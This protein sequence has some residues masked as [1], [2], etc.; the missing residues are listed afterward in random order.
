MAEE[1][2]E[3]FSDRHFRFKEGGETSYEYQVPQDRIE[4]LNGMTVRRI[5]VPDPRT[6][7]R[8]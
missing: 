2:E 4:E 6:K 8:C 5:R 1:F 3:Q 7:R